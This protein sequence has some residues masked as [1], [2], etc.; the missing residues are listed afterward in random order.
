[1]LTIRLSRIGKKKQ[2]SYR[3]IISEKTKDPWGKY[4][5]L[6][7]TFDPRSKKLDLKIERIK[8]WLSVGAQTSNT[9]NNLLIKAGVITGKKKKVVKLT[10]QRREKM[11]AK[12]K[13]KES[14]AAK[15]SGAPEAAAAPEAPE[16]TSE[17]TASSETSE[18]KIEPAS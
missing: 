6:L 18:A 5:E 13:A 12:A 11:A 1:M 17:K 10:T 3:L 15:A 14:E 9:I 2:P 4:L 7:G 8:Y 16:A